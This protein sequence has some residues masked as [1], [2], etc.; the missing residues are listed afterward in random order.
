MR[1]MSKK[2]GFR[3]LLAL[4]L[5]MA[6]LWALP[7]AALAA[8][9]NQAFDAYA[10]QIHEQV[11]RNWPLLAKV[12]PGH[13]YTRHDLLLAL[14]DD[15]L[16]P[17]AAYALNTQ[18]IKRLEAAEY[19]N[20]ALPQPGGYASLA[21]QGRPAVAISTDAY[22]LSQPGEAEEAYR[23]ATHELV[24]FYHQDGMVMDQAGSRAQ[25]YPVDLQPR[26]YRQML[27]LRMINAL[28]E[29]ARQ[30]EWLG[31][32][33]YWLDLWEKE[34]AEEAK[35]IHSTDMAEGSA[36]YIENLGTVIGQ[37]EAGG[38]RDALTADSTQKDERFVSADSESYE[39]GYVAGLLLDK[40]EPTW[41]EDFYARNLT[42]MQRLL[43]HTAPMEDEADPALRQQLTAE[44]EAINAEAGAALQDITAA[45]QDKRIPW[46]RIDNSDAIGSFQM[47]GN[48]WLGEA[49]ANT[50]MIATYTAGGNAIELKG[51]SAVTSVGEKDESYLI[52]PLTMAHKLEGGRLTV[53]HDQLS[54]QGVTI[55]EISE[56]GRTLYHVKADGE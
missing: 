18:G 25:P 30:Q 19:E 40:L 54:V 23:T 4:T 55:Q 56:D 13:D 8:P 20:L 28:E 46:L 43:A 42:P 44:I 2:T 36:R 21:Y 53:Q 24:H 34:Y 17:Q 33:R 37:I 16:Q 22:G 5:V 39:L 14:L 15:E 49:D 29:P 51:I 1:N 32:A 7:S 45:L 6:V 31:R 52:I 41:K 48:Y 47:N 11:K 3:A 10:A 38:D 35:A 26:L 9:E 27:Y 50:G 12:W